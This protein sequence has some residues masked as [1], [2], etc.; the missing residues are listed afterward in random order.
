MRK[1]SK[2]REMILQYL[3]D[4]K[5]HPTAEQIYSELKQKSPSLSLATVY[6]NLN[7]LCDLEK[8]QRLDTG[9]SE[10]RYDANVENHAHFIC[11]NCQGVTDIFDG[12]DIQQP[13]QSILGKD[14]TIKHH[15]L[16]IYGICPRCQ[17]AVKQLKK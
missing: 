17:S 4:N 8:V 16:Y 9:E 15:K 12:I 6:R 5:N 2:Q 7:L 3:L 10:D 11:E 14:Y 13:V 1:F